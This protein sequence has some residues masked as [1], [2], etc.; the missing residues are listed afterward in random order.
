MPLLPRSCPP[1]TA[2]QLSRNRHASPTDRSSNRTGPRAHRV[3]DRDPP[4]SA[5]MRFSANGA[6]LGGPSGCWVLRT[7]G[8]T[9]RVL[10]RQLPL[11]PP[12]APLGPPPPK[13]PSRSPPPPAPPIP[14]P[15]SPSLN[16]PSNPP[17]PPPRGLRPTISWGVVGVQNRGV[18]PPP[19][20]CGSN[21]S[22]LPPPPL[23]SCAPPPPPPRRP[24]PP[25]APLSSCAP[26]PTRRR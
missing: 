17:P 25:P 26:S 4:P 13:R 6:A 12:I 21:A 16:P 23:S 19:W 1:P 20:F 9:P 18:A 3:R 2:L 11:P 22:P 15:H 5:L 10:G 14:P 8:A 24:V 7:G